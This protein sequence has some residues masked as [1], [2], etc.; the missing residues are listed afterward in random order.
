[1]V[2]E[3][4]GYRNRGS[5]RKSGRSRHMTCLEACRESGGPMQSV[6]AFATNKLETVVARDFW[7]V[8]VRSMNPHSQKHNDRNLKYGQEGYENGIV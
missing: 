2:K 4:E 3:K 5:G 1:L 7:S 8:H 6:I